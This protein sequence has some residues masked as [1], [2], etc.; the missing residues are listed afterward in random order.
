[1]ITS[2]PQCEKAFDYLEEVM[3]L[4]EREAFEAHLEQCSACRSH[5]EELGTFE[6]RLVASLETRCGKSL[7]S[8]E[9]RV[10]ERIRADLPEEGGRGSTVRMVFRVAAGILAAA[11]LGWVVRELERGGPRGGEGEG[12]VARESSPGDSGALLPFEIVGPSS[13]PAADLS[14]GDGGPVQDFVV[15]VQS[16][17]RELVEARDQVAAA[18]SGCAEE[19]DDQLLPAF[20]AKIASLRHHG[21]PIE[22]MVCRLTKHEDDPVARSAIRLLGRTAR[23]GDVLVVSRCLEDPRL[24]DAAVRALGRFR[25][26]VAVAELTSWL[27]ESPDPIPVLRSLAGLQTRSAEGSIIRFA[28]ACLEEGS[29]GGSP[30]GREV[31]D[32]AI[33]ELAEFG[34]A[35]LEVFDE[36]LRLGAS[37]EVIRDALEP[38]RASWAEGLRSACRGDSRDFARGAAIRLLGVIGTEDDVPSLRMALQDR[39]YE[40]EVIHA[41]GRIGGA[42]A[43]ETLARYRVNGE[44]HRALA[45]EALLECIESLGGN[46]EEM[47]ALCDSLSASAFEGLLSVLGKGGGTR[48]VEG[49]FAIAE[50]AVEAER[51]A[52]ALLRLGG[53][54]IPELLSRCESFLVSTL[55]PKVRAAALLSSC[56][57]ASARE[58]FVFEHPIQR[59]VRVWSVITKTVRRWRESGDRPLPSALERIADVL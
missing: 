25:S 30:R 41:L 23:P 29:K 7:E 40:P 35:G 14:R 10:V 27:A 21:W 24:S 33:R 42:R 53:F 9:V 12:E 49:L 37:Q 43:A 38:H 34:V 17:E 59:D 16:P 11:S 48:G 54:E 32:E 28:R 26:E 56:R 5:L 39:K 52:A 6:E 1:M 3:T 13:V 18:L 46:S 4:S 50:S 20:E 19:D 57:L 44:N 45:D 8:S 51:K 22:N 58:T 2:C 36:F 15:T 31:V 55:D 47:K